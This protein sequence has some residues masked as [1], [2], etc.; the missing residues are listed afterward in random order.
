LPT[1]SKVSPT[2]SLITVPTSQKKKSLNNMQ[3][4]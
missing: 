2:S 3:Q 1:L 4:H